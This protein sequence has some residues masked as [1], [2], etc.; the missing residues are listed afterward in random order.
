MRLSKCIIIKMKALNDFL[1]CRVPALPDC[2]F[3]AQYLMIVV[4]GKALESLYIL[5]L[6]E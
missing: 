2:F 6:L 3:T 5:G 1:E 4:D